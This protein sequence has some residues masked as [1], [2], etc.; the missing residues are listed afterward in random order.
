MTS[1]PR[2]QQREEHRGAP[3]PLHGR[4]G[5]LAAPRPLDEQAERLGLLDPLDPEPALIYI[6]AEGI[7]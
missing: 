4:P 5:R 7:R 6:A 1:E 2:D 3:P